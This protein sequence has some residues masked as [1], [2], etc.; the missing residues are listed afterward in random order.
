MAN[1]TGFAASFPHPTSEMAT[2][3]YPIQ[4]GTRARDM[5]GN[6]YVY[7]DYTATVYSG[8]PVFISMD[9]EFTA[10]CVASGGR[11]PVGVACGAGTS[12]N[13]GWVQ[14]Y[15]YASMQIAGGDSAATSAMV[16]I[17]ASSVSSPQCAL[18]VAARTTDS[19]IEVHGLFVVGAATTD[20]T[21]AT[22]HIGVAVPVFLNYPF[23]FGAATS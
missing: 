11:G 7:C 3:P 5:D 8:I 16:A 18:N 20:T 13:A 15:G 21:S 4:P 22:S 2:T 14:I 1:L 17:L 12:D 19:D 9:G 10:T 6:E 23:Y